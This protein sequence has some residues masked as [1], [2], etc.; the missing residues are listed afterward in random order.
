[1]PRLGTPS[2]IK[3]ELTNINES[4]GG[5]STK[6]FAFKAQCDFYDARYVSRRRLNSDGVRCDQLAPDQHRPEEN[7]D[8]IE[9]VIADDDDGGAA[10][11]PSFTGAQGFDRRSSL[12]DET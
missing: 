12:A 8:A 5:S 6:L 9:E 2:R 3:F 4:S 7:L 10:C 1:M 11:G